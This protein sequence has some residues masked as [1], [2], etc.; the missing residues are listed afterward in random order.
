MFAGTLGVM[1]GAVLGYAL[2]SGQL[3]PEGWKNVGSLAA[4]WT[5]GSANMFA[6]KAAYEIPD[7]VFSPMIVVDSV[8]VY[9]WLGI[10]IAFAGAQEAYARRFGVNERITADMGARVR[11]FAAQEN[12]AATT[13]DIL[14]ILAI[15]LVGGHLCNLAGAWLNGMIKP[16]AKT[17]PALS[18]F[19]PMTIAIIFV[20]ALGILLSFSPVRRFERVGASRVGYAMLFL[21]LPTFGAQANL[22]EFG[23]I[24][25]YA[26]VGAVMLAFHAIFIFAAMRLLRAP[27]FFGAVGSQANVGGPASASIVASTY[28]QALAPVGILLGILGGITGTY[29]GLVTAQLC[30]F[31][32][33]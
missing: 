8:M 5:G 17:S 25:W 20:T 16:F 27:L 24:P 19:S 22:R 31:F 29:V 26:A 10:L 15:G 6:V 4:S 14:V 23:M 28:Q 12:H 2:F 7:P 11:E 30:R 9:S 32:A 3:D 13:R 18:T 33:P 21:L 1:I